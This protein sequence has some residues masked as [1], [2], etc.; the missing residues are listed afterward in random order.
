MKKGVIYILT[1]PSF[2]DWV[3]IGYAD[4]VEERVNQLNRTECTPFAFRI[5]A[6]YE[7]SSR[8]MDKKMHTIID[9]LNRNLRSVDEYNGRR[10][11]REFFA[12]S[13]EDA[14]A[15]F[16][17]MAE[18]HGCPERL[19]KWEVTPDCR[20]DEE[21]AEDVAEESAYRRQARCANF[22]FDHWQLPVGAVL[23]YCEDPSIFC[24]IVDNR[25]LSYNG[26]VMYMTPFAKKVSGKNYITNG[27][28]WV[29]RHFKYNGELLIDIEAR[30]YSQNENPE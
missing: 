14:Y 5:Y 3:K 29:S 18:I 6:T 21:I 10:R 17:A 19:V 27:P 16:E 11:E 26:E 22:T 2:K 7:V 13:P 15:I 28:G 30:I 25:H 12:I 8:L 20:K 9:K 4:N 1:N 23:E 24:T